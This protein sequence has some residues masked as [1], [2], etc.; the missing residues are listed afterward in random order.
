[1]DKKTNLYNLAM[2]L[3]NK[4]YIWGG[5]T[6]I[7]GMD[8]SGVVCE[9]LQSLGF[10]KNS[11]E[12]NAQNLYTDFVKTSQETDTP[13]FGSLIFFGKDLQS[14]SHVGFGLNKTQMIEA[15]GGTSATVSEEIA[16]K[17]NAY[18]KIRPYRHRSD[19]LVILNPNYSWEE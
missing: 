12:M 10:V 18:V 11:E 5:K 14:I 16:E 4:P 19:L 8:C 13:D 3:L 1:M 9:L 7:K 15:G 17:T 2:S 6:P